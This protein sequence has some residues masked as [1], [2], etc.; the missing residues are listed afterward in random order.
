MP[1]P[2]LG[3]KATVAGLDRA[4]L[5]RYHQTYFRPDNLV[6]SLAGRVTI[7]AVALVSQV[8]VTGSAER[9]HCPLYPY[10]SLTRR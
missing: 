2:G 4:D 3:C 7:D 9:R 6:I 1:L 5:E 10:L 8:L